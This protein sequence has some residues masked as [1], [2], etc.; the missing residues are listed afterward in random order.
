MPLL[1]LVAV[2]KFQACHHGSEK[3][4]SNHA[5]E[6]ANLALQAGN[7]VCGGVGRLGCKAPRSGPTEDAQAFCSLA[8]FASLAS[9]SV[10]LCWEAPACF[11]RT[12]LRSLQQR[13]CRRNGDVA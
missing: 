6:K 2:L 5:L 8:S 4:P 7:D 9:R 13:Q 1:H 3:P 11:S 12:F 10:S